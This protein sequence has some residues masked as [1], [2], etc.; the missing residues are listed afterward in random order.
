[1]R[2]Y[3]EKLRGR[4]LGLLQEVSQI[5]HNYTKLTFSLHLLLPLTASSS[6]A[7]K[8]SISD[9]EKKLTLRVFSYIIIHALFYIFQVCK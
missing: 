5:H 7:V 8:F 9:N 6:K 2:C 4:Q 1:M 3:Y